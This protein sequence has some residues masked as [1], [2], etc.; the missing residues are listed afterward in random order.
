MFLLQVIRSVGG[1]FTKL[2]TGEYPMR[3]PEVKTSLSGKQLQRILDCVGEQESTKI[4]RKGFGYLH[5]W[6]KII[7][8]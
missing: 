5:V 3:N 2:I 8:W 1:H 6:S 4:P 7:I